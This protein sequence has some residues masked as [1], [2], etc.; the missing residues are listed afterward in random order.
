MMSI[1]SP[2]A[3]RIASNL[4]DRAADSTGFDAGD[5][6]LFQLKGAFWSR[7]VTVNANTVSHLATEQ[8]PDRR[9]E[10]LGP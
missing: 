7:S 9:I 3:F 6:L 10:R 1:S 4:V 5:A 2:T 8:V